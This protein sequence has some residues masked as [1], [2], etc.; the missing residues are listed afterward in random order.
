MQTLCKRWFVMGTLAVMLAGGLS[1]VVPAGEDSKPASEFTKKANAAVLKELPFNDRQDYED[2]QRGF[3]AP[4]EGPIKNAEG[5]VVWDI[6]PFDFLKDDTSPDTVN[7]SLWRVSQLNL[8]NGLFKVRDGVYQIRGLDIANMTIIEG[9][10][11]LIIID[12]LISAETA[13]AGL[14]LYYKHLDPKRTR[15]LLAA[16]F[17][18]SHAD[19]FGGV[20]GVTSEAEV[21]AGKVRVIAP[22]GFLMEAVSEN[23]YAG[24][25]MNRRA[26]YQYGN[27][28]PRG[29]RENVTVG[30]GIAL[31]SGAV[32]ILAPTDIIKKSGE[33]R[34]ID[35]VEIEFQ[36]APG[37]EA[38]AE[39]L[40][41]FPGL[42]MLCAAE[43]ATHTLHNLYTLRGAKVRDSNLWWKALD[44]AVEHF[45]DRTDVIVAQHHWPKWGQENV[46]RFLEIQRDGYKYMHDQT[47]FYAN[48]GYTPIEIAE[49]IKFP[50]AIDKQWYMRGYYGSLSHNVK[51]VYQYYLGWYDGHPA[52]LHPLPPVEAAKRYV[53]VMGGSAAAIK[54][55]REYFDKGDYRFVSEMMKHV[56][57]AEPDNVE[58]KNLLADSFEQQ[59]YQEECGTWRPAFLMGAYELRHG[60][61]RFPLTTVSPTMMGAMTT[62]MILDFM[63]LKLD[64]EKAAGKK[65]VMN[66]TL[67]DTK[68]TFQVTLENNVL[69]YRAGKLADKPDAE[70]TLDKSAFI[71]LGLA[72]KDVDEV[73]KMPGVTIR[74]PKK[75]RE[76]VSCLKVFTPAFNIVTP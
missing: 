49:T 19:H 53:D 41:Y 16:I 2:A 70:L 67:P 31:S 40:M 11:G 62:E 4:M 26:D 54:K 47:L 24:N 71:A 66:L 34:T 5:R 37:T 35:G 14:D 9:K 58:A 69:M 1:A 23:V 28:L 74:N 15:P 29:P 48:Q 21:K 51:A 33:T 68:E 55:A 38:P 8:K 22:E 73:A 7:P 52:N 46:K 20:L 10:T 59:G 39:M 56:V 75:V 18:H 43:D 44:Y 25:A 50:E 6:G 30:L 60:L 3:I 63:G 57:F 32:G 64:T 17:S 76:V 12:F 36:M 42:K 65:I 13:R 61:L 27:P 72:G 45:G